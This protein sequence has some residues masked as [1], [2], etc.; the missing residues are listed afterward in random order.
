MAQKDGLRMLTGAIP[1]EKSSVAG[2]SRGRAFLLYVLKTLALAALYFVVA[3][4]SL[5]LA[6]VH[7][8]VSPLWPPSGVAIAV[9]FLAGFRLSPGVLLGAALATYST[10]VPI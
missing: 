4:L 10:G 6:L 8:H 2:R 5:V 7:A 1:T 9:L 3:R